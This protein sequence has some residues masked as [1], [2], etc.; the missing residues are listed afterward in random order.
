MYYNVTVYLSDIAWSRDL[1]L[2]LSDFTVT[3]YPAIN[4]LGSLWPCYFTQKEQAREFLWHLLRVQY[5]KNNAFVTVNNDFL[6]TREVICQWFSLVTSSHE[7]TSENHWQITT[8]VTKK[9]LFTVT[10]VLFYFLHAILCL[11][12]TILLQTI[13]ELWF[14]HWR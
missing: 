3:W 8:R 4:I 9:S 6:V 5:I 14:P 13:I 7:V 1:R 2:A 11:E 12:Y 10:N